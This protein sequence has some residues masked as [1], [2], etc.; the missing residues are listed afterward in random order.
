MNYGKKI[1]GFTKAKNLTQRTALASAE[2][3]FS[4]VLGNFWREFEFFREMLLLQLHL[5][6]S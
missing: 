5:L 2:S 4:P 3:I 6:S 1:W